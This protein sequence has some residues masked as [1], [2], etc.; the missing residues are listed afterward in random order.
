M[1]TDKVVI[2]MAFLVLLKAYIFPKF[3]KMTAKTA[4]FEIIL[5]FHATKQ[6]NAD[7]NL[8]NISF[9]IFNLKF[10]VYLWPVKRLN[11]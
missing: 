3:F 11:N 7:E 5:N 6:E 2:K 8:N 1:K 4:F 9:V 10:L